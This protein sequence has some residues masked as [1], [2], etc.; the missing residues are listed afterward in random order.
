MVG[1]SSLNITQLQ[2]MIDEVR[3]KEPVNEEFIA[4]LENQIAKNRQKN[5]KPSKKP[6]AC[7]MIEKRI[8]MVDDKTP[9]PPTSP[10][11]P[12]E[13]IKP[14]PLR[15]AVNLLRDYYRKQYLNDETPQEPKQIGRAHV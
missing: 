7:N 6:T 8:N 2:K 4:K 12:L 11:R 14:V 5:K 10:Q 15:Q 9:S 3:A 13:E 1:L